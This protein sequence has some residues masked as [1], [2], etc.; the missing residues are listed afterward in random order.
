MT[1]LVLI[2]PCSSFISFTILL[3][4]HLFPQPLCTPVIPPPNPPP[5][6]TPNH[7]YPRCPSSFSFLISS[8]LSFSLPPVTVSSLPLLLFLLLH[9]ILTCCF[10][11]LFLVL[12]V[13]FQYSSSSASSS[14]NPPPPSP[15]VLYQPLIP[16][17]VCHA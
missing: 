14:S 8:F 17:C 15:A 12:H 6:V 2:L 11:S 4:F 16:C 13:I 10:V 7:S 1:H 3:I 9:S 5:S